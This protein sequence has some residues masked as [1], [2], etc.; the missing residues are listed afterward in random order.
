MDD[1]LARAAA[2][3]LGFGVAQIQRLAK[4]FDGFLETRGRLGFHQRAKLAGDVR[5][6]IGAHAHGHAPVR[7]QSVDGH[8]KG[9]NHAGDGGLLEEQRL[10][11]AGRFHLAV[12]E[13]GDFEFGGHGLGDAFQLARAVKRVHKIA[14]GIKSHACETKPNRRQGKENASSATCA[15]L[16]SFRGELA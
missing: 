9:R 5:H 7:T 12:G 16:L 11:A 13:F 15:I 8:G 14:E 6:G 1:F 2:D 4:Q 10:A 3:D